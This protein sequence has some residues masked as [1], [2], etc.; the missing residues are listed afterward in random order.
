MYD[1]DP[2][3]SVISNIANILLIDIRHCQHNISDIDVKLVY[4]G[5]EILNLGI[6]TTPY[7]IEIQD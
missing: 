6:N 7:I 4:T 2:I 3:I 5:S 1:I